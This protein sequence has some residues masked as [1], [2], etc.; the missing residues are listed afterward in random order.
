MDTRQTEAWE[1]CEGCL[2]L[3]RGARWRERY[4]QTLCDECF[5]FAHET[6]AAA[7]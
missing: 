2:E 3:R 5:A 1:W 6:E 4:R 7:A